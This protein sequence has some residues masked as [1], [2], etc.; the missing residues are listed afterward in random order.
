MPVSVNFVITAVM[1]HIDIKVVDLNAMKIVYVLCQMLLYS[2]I[3]CLK[4]VFC[5]V[6][7]KNCVQLTWKA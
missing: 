2:Q 3:V 6:R 1:V 5:E 7:L 4:H